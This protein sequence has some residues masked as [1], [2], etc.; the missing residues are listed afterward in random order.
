MIT[1]FDIV[2]KIVARE[3]VTTSQAAQHLAV[4][5]SAFRHQCNVHRIHP[6]HQVPG[7]T[8]SHLWATADLAAIPTWQTT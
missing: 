2:E 8:G 4:S 1:Q 3:W 7:Q 5:V 6:V